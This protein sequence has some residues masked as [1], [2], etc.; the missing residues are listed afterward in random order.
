MGSVEMSMSMSKYSLIS[1][2]FIIQVICSLENEVDF[3]LDNDS[4]CGITTKGKEECTWDCEVTFGDFGQEITNPECLRDCFE[5]TPCVGKLLDDPTCCADTEAQLRRRKCIKSVYKKLPLVYSTISGMV[6]DK[7]FGTKADT[8]WLCFMLVEISAN[9]PDYKSCKAAFKPTVTA[10]SCSSNNTTENSK[11]HSRK[12]RLA[13]LFQTVNLAKGGNIRTELDFENTRH[14]Y[15]WICSLR[16]STKE[17]L[18]AVTLLRRPPGPTVLVGAAHCTYLCKNKTEDVVNNCCCASGPENCAKNTTRCGTD[19]KVSEM[20]SEDADIICGEWETG[21]M[22]SSRSEEE[23]ILSI[24]EI[25]R[26]P[27]FNTSSGPG[28]GNDIAVF[29]VDNVSLTSEDIS[30]LTPTCLPSSSSSFIG[31]SAVHSGWF[32]PPP[33]SFLNEYAPS[34]AKNRVYRDFCK[35][36]HYQMEITECRDPLTNPVTGGELKH[37]SDSFYPAGTVCAKEFTRLSCFSTGSSGSPLMTKQSDM[38]YNTEGILSFIKGCDVF[39]FGVGNSRGNRYFLNQQSENPS[40]YTKLSC[41]LPWVAS[42]YNLTYDGVV[43]D[44]CDSND[45]VKETDGVCRNTPSNMLEA[46]QN[47]EMKCIF[48]FYYDGNKYESCVLF[49]QDDFVYP[50]FRCPIRNIT[51]KVDG[52]NSFSSDDLDSILTGGLCQ[53]LDAQNSGDLPPLS[54]NITDCSPGQRRVPFSQCKND[55]PGVRAFGVIGG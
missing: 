47:T 38:R 51:T 32:K 40:V 37:L 46:V 53:D 14:R 41:F 21:T 48:P 28:D 45:S 15:P 31:A 12:K 18:C 34:Y 43:G 39:A 4:Q 49:N 44:D 29:K 1:I 13:P 20:T 27:N 22:K 9:F 10:P 3:K 8:N 11:G 55:C 2:I 19:P 54:V 16:G 36:W 35:Q 23:Y 24:K 42:Q 25:I 17:H 33:K 5:D 7:C 50:T 6:A 52:I 30:K 26:H